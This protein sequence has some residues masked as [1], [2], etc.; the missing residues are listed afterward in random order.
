MDIEAVK[1]RILHKIAE[2]YNDEYLVGWGKHEGHHVQT[3]EM[4]RIASLEDHINMK[5]KLYCRDC[6][7]TFTEIW[8]IQ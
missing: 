3:L 7:K 6:D 2:E 5:I 4:N 8:S 1:K